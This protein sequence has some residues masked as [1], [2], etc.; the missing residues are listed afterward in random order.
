MN[1]GKSV[2]KNVVCILVDK[3]YIWFWSV[4]EKK[5]LRQKIHS[6]NNYLENPKLSVAFAEEFCW[7]FDM[8]GE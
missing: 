5:L 6:I 7:G 3:F 2:K 8:T 4:I 1:Y